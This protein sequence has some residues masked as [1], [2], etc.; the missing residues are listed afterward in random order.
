VLK[1]V[2]AVE[3]DTENITIFSEKSQKEVLPYLLD[4][5]Y[6]PL[7]DEKRKWVAFS[8]EKKLKA[9]RRIRTKLRDKEKPQKNERAIGHI[10][11][12]SFKGRLLTLVNEDNEWQKK[13]KRKDILLIMI[14]GERSIVQ[15]L[16]TKISA[17]TAKAPLDKMV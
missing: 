16:D 8:I 14:L 11:I 4:P 10:F 15:H 7:I 13:P 12:H 17:I 3:N 9:K 6:K 1:D 5:S 2:F